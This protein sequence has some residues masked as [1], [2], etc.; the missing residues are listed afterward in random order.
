MKIMVLSVTDYAIIK[1]VEATHHQGDV[2]MV[3]LEVFCA[4]VSLLFQ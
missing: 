4:D 2:N 1:V 3:H